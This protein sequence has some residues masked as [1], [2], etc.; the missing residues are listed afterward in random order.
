MDRP[1]VRASD[2]EREQAGVLLRD[3]A[4]EGRLTFEELADRIDVA[5]GTTTRGELARLTADLPRPAGSEAPVA[6]PVNV[7]SLLG[8][9]KRSG[10]W[11][12][13]ARSR[14][15]TGLGDVVLDL[16]EARVSGPEVVIDARTV[17]G[18]VDLLVPESVV[19]EIRS[20]ALIGDVRQ[21]AGSA[22]PPGAPRIV[23][24]GGSVFGDV[25]VRAKRLREK[26]AARFLGA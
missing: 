13:P 1:D 4:A 19:V 7:S 5:S 18:D 3:A 2:A 22:G 15:R 10:A 23:L 21:E 14:W 25:R 8:D 24:V 12:V 17:F 26:L 6:A 16:R 11:V 20:R 9:V